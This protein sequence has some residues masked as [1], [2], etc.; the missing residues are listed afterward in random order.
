MSEIA[1]SKGWDWT[2]VS[3]EYAEEWKNPSVESFYLINRWKNQNKKDFLD[4]GC[5]LGRHAILFSKNKF[6]T[7]AFDISNTAID[8][9]KKWAKTENLD[10]EFILAD[11]IFLPY[12]DNSFDCVLC[13]NSISH[14]NTKGM[15]QVIS[16][17]KRVLRTGGEAFLTLGAKSKWIEDNWPKV[18]ENTYSCMEK[19]EY[20]VPHFY[21][22]YDLIQKMFADFKIK[23][24]EKVGNFHKAGDK[25]VEI[26]HYHILIKK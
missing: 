25:I 8:A 11:M 26:Y 1:N 23:S 3:K 17:L 24:I 6:N 14:T 13:R 20:N 10:I 4:F 2:L 18:D 5:G 9:A 7:F 16:E 22:D 21:A 12:A 15:I 19:H